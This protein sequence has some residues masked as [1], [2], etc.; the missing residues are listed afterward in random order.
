MK[1]KSINLNGIDTPVGGLSWENIPST[2][3]EIKR[4]ILFLNSKRILMAPIVDSFNRWGEQTYKDKKEPDYV[5]ISILNIKEFITHQQIEKVIEDVTAINLLSKMIQACNDFLDS[6]E[7]FDKIFVNLRENRQSIVLSSL[8]RDGS[9]EI[10][11]K[12]YM[13]VVLHNADVVSNYRKVM[14]QNV[15]ELIRIFKIDYKIEF[16]TEFDKMDFKLPT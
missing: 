14:Q 11:T 8:N 5:S 7:T 16:P 10:D 15:N 9:G 13:R 12:E 3:I 6:W 4:I 2:A 1:K